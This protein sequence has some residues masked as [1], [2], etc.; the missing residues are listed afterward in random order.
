MR[1]PRRL[2]TLSLLLLSAAFAVSAFAQQPPAPAPRAKPPI[3]HR[4]VRP[5]PPKPEAPA[6]TPE[7]K[8]TLMGQFGEW[9]AYTA[10]PGGKKVCFAIAKPKTSQVVPADRPRNPAY[11]FITT[12]P[13]DKVTDEV[14]IIIGYPFRSN[15][16]ATAQVGTTTFAL[17]TQQDGAWIKNAAEEAHMVEAM[18]AADNVVVKGVSTKGT[19]STDTFSLK[20]IS[21]ALD[22]MAQECK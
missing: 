19:R 15:S 11:M 22:R 20:G 8:P 16:D 4:H 17:Y 12:R 6:A 3:K 5:P 18:R 1:I 14:S 21:Q 10:S 7:E 2:A 9:G 13:A